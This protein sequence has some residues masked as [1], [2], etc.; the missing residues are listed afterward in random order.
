MTEK[1]QDID[2]ERIKTDEAFFRVHTTQTL[3]IIE[4]NIRKL[5]EEINATK[6]DIAVIKANLND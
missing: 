4:Q 5:T 3:S 1:N 6:E 2:L